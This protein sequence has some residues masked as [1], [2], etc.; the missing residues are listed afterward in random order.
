VSIRLLADRQSHKAT[1]RPA[2][3][4]WNSQYGQGRPLEVRLA[5]SRTLHDRAVL[6]D[7]TAAWTLTQ[8]LNAFATR[9]P[10]MIVRVD[11]ETAAL[12][13]SAYEAMWAA[14]TPL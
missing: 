7:S 11:D 4:H 14:A 13:I 12:K 3:T 1:L 5:P 2:Q 8:S 10:A 9:S 6:V